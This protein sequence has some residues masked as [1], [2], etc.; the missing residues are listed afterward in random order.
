M[1]L[2][3]AVFD[4]DGTLLDSMP[5]WETMGARYLQSIEIGC[6]AKNDVDDV[7]KDLSPLQT[8]Q[9]YQNAYGVTLSI[10]E[11]M[12]G[13]N[14]MLEDFYRNEALLKPGVMDLLRLLNKK[15]VKMCIATATDRCLVEPALERCG[16]TPYIGKIFTCT[17]VGHGKDEPQIFEAARDFLG[18][19]R[20]DTFVFEDALYA[21]KTAK[22]AGFPVAAVYDPSEAAQGRVQALCDVFLEDLTQ[23]DGLRQFLPS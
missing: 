2:C 6:D 3:S 17:E 12:A 10:D 16:V 14:A 9:Y 21:I 4:M 15:G 23:L 18:T 19:D 7:V 8:A 5:I 11:I 20:E 1:T 22:D 13:I